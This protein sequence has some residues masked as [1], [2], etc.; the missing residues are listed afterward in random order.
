MKKVFALP[1]NYN[2]DLSE[3]L[4]S[5]LFRNVEIKI[6]GFLFLLFDMSFVSCVALHHQVH[7]LK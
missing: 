5:G 3:G 1:L 4:S 2:V 7:S 6:S